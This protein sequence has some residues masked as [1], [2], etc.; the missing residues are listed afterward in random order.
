MTVMPHREAE[1]EEC[2]DPH[3][4]NDNLPTDHGKAR[5]PGRRRGN[6][7]FPTAGSQKLCI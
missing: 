5:F 6:H 2:R 1:M 7:I 4:H 3:S